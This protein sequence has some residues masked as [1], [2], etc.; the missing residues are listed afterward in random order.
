MAMFSNGNDVFR[1]QADT[2]F[3][4]FADPQNSINQNNGAWG[5]DPN[6]LTPSFTS[7]FRPQYQGPNGNTYGRSSPGV[8]TSVNQIFNPFAGGGTNYG[9]NTWQQTSPYFDSL[10]SRPMD[11]AASFAQN[12]AVPAAAT[13]GAYKYLG[14]G[15]E[16]LGGAMGAG[17]TRGMFGLPAGATGTAMSIGRGLGAMA[18]SIFLPVAAATAASAGFDSAIAD[19]YIAQRQMG[20]NLRDNFSGI[21]FGEGTGDRFTGGGLSRQFAQNISKRT[22]MAGAMD[23][24]FT[25]QE[26]SQLA[27]LSSR[28]GLLDSTSSTQMASKFEGI[29]KQVK[30]VMAIANTSDFKETIEIMSKMSMSGVSNTALSSAMGRLGA[31]AGSGGQ[32]MQKMMNTVGA[33]GQYMFG[34]AGLTPYAGME[35]GFGASAAHSAAYRSGLISPAM[36]ARMGGKEGAAQS[37]IAGTIGMYSTPYAQMMGSNAYTGG[38]EMGN[39]L[40]NMTQFGG[41]MSANP[42]QSI[43][44]FYATGKAMTSKMIGERGVGGEMDMIHQIA[45]SIPGGLDKNGKVTGEVAYMIMTTQMGLPPEVAT[46][47]L[48][49]FASRLSPETNKAMVAGVDTASISAISKYR[50]QESL[51]KGIFTTPINAVKI[52]MMKVQRQGAKLVGNAMEAAGG[53]ADSFEN[54]MNEAWFQ[55]KDDEN[56]MTVAQANA[57]VT[58]VKTFDLSRGL[59]TRRGKNGEKSVNNVDLEYGMGQINKAIAKGDPDAIAFRDSK[60]VAK[61]NAAYRLA[62]KGLLD[63]KYADPEH[64]SR[65]ASVAETAN[66]VTEGAKDGAKNAED[67]VKDKLNNIYSGGSTDGALELLAVS[68]RIHMA[69][70]AGGSGKITDE[71]KEVMARLTGKSNLSDAQLEQTANAVF[72]RGASEGVSHYA[73]LRVGKDGTSAD[74]VKQLDEKG[75][76]LLTPKVE[77]EDLNAISEQVQV[78]KANAKQRANLVALAKNGKM[79]L[80]SY[81]SATA[82]LDNKEAVGKFADAV[83]IFAKAVDTDR[84]TNGTSPTSGVPTMKEY[85]VDGKRMAKN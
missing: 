10:A 83:N 16:R 1:T 67:R 51:D 75:M 19:P 4:S 5:V 69:T 12:W 73:G 58:G 13:F 24:T 50:Q 22:S 42:L 68:E 45:K 9:G 21:S 77:G 71:D 52:P 33:Q 8:G 18:G 82:A 62:K 84:G 66:L 2:R 49:E 48:A 44:A 15:S 23:M 7:P 17:I 59:S 37:S 32:S 20:R 14:K 11:V 6:Y 43:G 74:L 53:I 54:Y 64:N 39:V 57:S 79:D 34:A 65:L 81:M 41:R 46:A 63:G 30:V 27:D 56:G 31:M 36:M 47:K 60:G 61:Q 55:V 25:Q 70:K 35:S 3:N 29:M 38:G 80:S 78:Q 28:A 85:F 26:T 40:S 72:K 76:K